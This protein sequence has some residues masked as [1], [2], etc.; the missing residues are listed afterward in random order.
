MFVILIGPSSRRRPSRSTRSPR[1]AGRRGCLARRRS[2]AI[3]ASA[4]SNAASTSSRGRSP[5]Q[6]ATAA[7]ISSTCSARPAPVANH[8]SLDR[9]AR[10]TRR[11][12]RSAMRSRSPRP[13][14]R[15]RRRCGRRCA[16]RCGSS[17]CRSAAGAPQQVVGGD[18]RAEQR[19]Q[20]LDERGVDDLA[21]PGRLACAE[22]DHDRERGRERRDAVGERERRQQR[23]AVR[24]AVQRGESAHR[25]GER[26]EAGRRAYGP[27]WPKPLTRASTSRG[28]TAESS[29]QPSAPALERPGTEVLEHDVGRSAS[30]RKT[31]ALPAGRGRA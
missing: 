8:G 5:I 2:G 3:A 30:R 7:S 25:L 9:S 15:S 26:A 12:T 1:A 10:P 14:P 6:A 24:L 27:V 17:G 19:H 23:R 28:L 4:A 13:R 20:R 16:A 29:S 22:R 31:R 21:P 11:R 18:L